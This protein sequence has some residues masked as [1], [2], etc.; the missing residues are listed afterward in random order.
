MIIS[1][2]LT[3]SDMLT[4]AMRDQVALQI[5][6]GLLT[7]IGDPLSEDM[8]TIG[9]TMRQGWHP[10]RAQERFLQLLR[11]ASA[12]L[13]ADASHKSAIESAWRI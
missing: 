2:L 8:P 13:V 4:L 12:S 5:R 3:G 1:R 7:Q 6:T 10:T 9:V 11:E